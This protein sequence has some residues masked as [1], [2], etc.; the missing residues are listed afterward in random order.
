MAGLLAA[1]FAAISALTVPFTSIPSPNATP[2]AE[3]SRAASADG[4]IQALS[5]RST[6]EG[7]GR[8]LSVPEMLTGVSPNRRS[9]L[10]IWITSLV[11]CP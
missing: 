10:R 5:F 7:L 6:W 1:P 4:G 11:R 2:K 3:A 9:P 8:V